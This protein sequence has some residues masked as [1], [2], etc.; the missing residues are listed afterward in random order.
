MGRPTPKPIYY[1]HN[2]NG[3]K[4]LTRLRLR[5]SYL[6]E[7]KFNHNFNECVNLLCSC[8]LEVQS[9]PHF[10]LLCHHFI[11]IRK[12]LFH[13]LQPVNKNILHQSDNEISELLLYVSSKFKL[14]QNCSI[15]RSS[16]K[17]IIKS[18]RFSGSI[19]R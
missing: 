16:I 18:E 7:H 3:L 1:I 9:A 8:S 13:E 19:V 4:L 10:F 15:L 6:N 17:F 2:P 11:D 12:T 5:I 14:Q